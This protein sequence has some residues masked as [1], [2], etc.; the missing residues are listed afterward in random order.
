VTPLEFQQ[1]L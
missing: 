1:D